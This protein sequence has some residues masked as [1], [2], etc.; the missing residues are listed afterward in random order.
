LILQNIDLEPAPT[1]CEFAT[2]KPG[3]L[4]KSLTCHACIK[5]INALNSMMTKDIQV[6]GSVSLVQVFGSVAQYRAGNLTLQAQ[7]P[8]PLDQI[9]V[10]SFQLTNNLGAL[11]SITFY[12]C[13]IFPWNIRI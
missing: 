4:K 6:I 10:F 13:S 7:F 2:I 3:L 5:T 12:A 8:I 1:V 9:F 11:L